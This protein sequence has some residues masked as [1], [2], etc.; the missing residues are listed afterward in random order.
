M[1]THEMRFLFHS[2][3]GHPNLSLVKAMSL[4]DTLT[5]LKHPQLFVLQSQRLSAL[6]DVVVAESSVATNPDAIIDYLQL[7]EILVDLLEKSQLYSALPPHQIRTREEEVKS[8]LDKIQTVQEAVADWDD[9]TSAS[10][11]EGSRKRSRSVD[12]DE[13]I[14]R[15]LKRP[16]ENEMER[17]M[18]ADAVHNRLSTISLP[19]IESLPTAWWNEPFYD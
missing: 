9:R 1:K 17:D 6:L 16:R 13:E 18:V 2:L 15:A 4:P 8:F 14:T 12:M 7:T 19:S 11:N 5:D 3:R 10:N